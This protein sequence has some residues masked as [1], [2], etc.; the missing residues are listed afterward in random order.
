MLP[1]L[2]LNPP[3]PLWILMSDN[4]CA[5]ALPNKCF[6]HTST[7][8][9][10]LLPSPRTCT[11]RSSRCSNDVW[12]VLRHQCLSATH[13]R[14]H[15]PIKTNE[16]YVVFMLS[17][18]TSTRQLVSLSLPRTYTAHHPRCSNKV[19]TVLRH[20]GFSATCHKSHKPIKTSASYTVFVLSQWMTTLPWEIIWSFC[21]RAG[22]IFWALKS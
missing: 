10:A 3:L 19:W 1:W 22:K 13:H 4:K 9:L 15:R 17:Q 18:W 5:S 7:R 16:C 12:T 21:M 14:S 20:Q 8:W 6:T 11:E 2:P